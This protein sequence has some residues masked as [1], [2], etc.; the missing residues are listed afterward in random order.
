M[1]AALRQ[2]G[3]LGR[4]LDEVRLACVD[5]PPE[6]SK[7]AEWLLDN[8][9]QVQRA[10]RQIDKD[11][12]PSFYRKLS[13]LDDDADGL[14]RIYVLAHEFLRASHLQI[15]LPGAVRFIQ[16][17][18]QRQPLTIAELWAFP[19]MARIACVE[20]LAVTLTP[21]LGE[22][23]KLP[24]R[25]PSA[26]LDPHSLD[27][28]E[29]VARAISNLGVIAAIPW[30][31]FFD[32]TSLVEE[33]LGHDP[34]GHYPE[35][36]FE[37]RD[38]YRGAVER[39]AWDSHRDESE[40]TDAAIR[41]SRSFA[42]GD[43]RG[44][45]GYWLVDQG[46]S[47][48]ESELGVEVSRREKLR[49]LVK[50]HPGR[51]Y[52]A[53]LLSAGIGAL[54]LPALYLAWVGASLPGWLGAMAVS[55][56]PASVLAITVV[57]WAI[58]RVIPPSVLPK[59]DCRKRLP[60]D[61]NS[62]VVVPVVIDTKEE[63][64]SLARQLETHFLA[65]TDPRVQVAL[66]AD[67]ADAPEEE[68]PGD[69]AIVEA[70]VA[71]I[72][73]LNSR[74]AMGGHGP[75]HLLLRPRRYNSGEGS[76]MA[77]ERK[78]GKLEQF[79]RLLVEGDWS[80]FS[81]HEGIRAAFSDVRYVV[82][83]DADTLL[84]PGSVARLVGT[85][86]HPLNRAIVNRETGR[87]QRGY[88]LV[89]PRVEIS[90]QAGIRSV[91][92]RL[93]TGDTAIDIYSRAVSD[94]YQDLF[95]AG[96]YVGKGIY[97][98]RAFH[99]AVDGRVPENRILSHDLFEGALGHAALATDIV[100]YENFPASYPEYARRLHRWIRGDWQ[101]LAWLWPHVPGADG[102]RL[103][104][105]ISGIDRWKILDNLRRSLVAPGLLILA[106]AGWFVLPGSPWFWTALVVLAPG[107]QLFTDIVSGLARG[108]RVGASYGLL[109][110]LSDQTGRW[111][112]AM[113]YLLH[114]ALLSLHAIMVTLWRNLVSHKHLL[115]WTAAAHVA[116]RISQRS[117]RFSNWREMWLGPVIAVTI[118]TALVLLR[119][120]ALPAAL[121]LLVPWM[122]APE[123]AL[124]SGRPRRPKAVP[125]GKGDTSY[126]RLL[127]R[128]TWYYF[129]S[130]AGPE[131][132][133]LPP[134][135]Y[136]GP[137]FEEIAHRTSPT[138]I[139]MLLL[140]TASAWD[141]G[142][143]GRAELAARGHNVFDALA[144]L[145]RYRG[146]FYNW[147]ETRHLHP[148]EPRYVSVV[149]SG[150]LAVSLIAY[151][152]TLRQAASQNALE[153]QRWTGLADLLELV[154]QA[155][156]HFE[157]ANGLRS[158]IAEL[159]AKVKE[160]EDGGDP[161]SSLEW[162]RSTVLPSIAEA[163]KHLAQSAADTGQEPLHDLFAWIDRLRHHIDEMHR[164]HATS[165]DRSDDLTADLQALAEDATTLAWSMDFSW[166]YDRERRLF[167]I[168]HNVTASRIDT[169]HY[170]LLASEARL[171]SFFAIAKGDV[172]IEHWFH[173]ERPVT[174]GP[175]GLS[176]MSWNGSMFEYLMPRLLLRGE[177]ETLLGE[178]ERV[179]VEIQRRYGKARGLPWGVS[180]SAYAERDP[181]HRYRYQAFGIP[182]LGL[183]RGL[184]RDQVIAP[185]ASGLALAV[186][187][188]QATANLRALSGLGAE[189]RYGMWEALDFTPDRAPANGR[190]TPVV[191]YMAHHQGMMLCAIA[192]LLTN[193]RMVARFAGG[194]QIWLVSLLL[195][196]RVPHEIPPEI[197]RREAL[198]LPDSAGH[199]EA[200]APWEPALRRSR[201]CKCL[202][203][204]ACRAGFPK[205]GAA[206]CVGREI[207]S[208]GSSRTQRATRT[209]CGFIFMTRI[210]AR[211]GP[212]PVSRR[213]RLLTNSEFSSSLTSSNSIAATTVST[214]GW[215]WVWVVATIWKF[216]D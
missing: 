79:N 98:V 118:A 106:L 19:T 15:S 113:V 131:D 75:F 25:P 46:C 53:T 103:K 199:V 83:V 6:A 77:W 73:S 156:S 160:L 70:L 214:R 188:G 198:E 177:P 5:P 124:W 11:M 78:R 157:Q 180:E 9:Y 85:I 175:G 93:F 112:Q 211:H 38:N 42:S 67:L 1:V 212:Q 97:D 35:M 16:G 126:L 132:N 69:H 201:K 166:L 120:S 61:A 24:F 155:A 143:L 86:S 13:A 2:I 119:P 43:I 76:W 205:A 107:W 29:C 49:K 95:G 47:E 45:V 174:R 30:E 12:P 59:L 96:I 204:V 104:N 109:A 134:D 153:A 170:D 41:L 44:H 191:A 136:Q 56:I 39:L 165:R 195:S 108:R 144:R 20:V 162:M 8:D 184:A 130:F 179:A 121:W 62:F 68:M 125:L 183:K 89:Q 142:Y 34:S 200:I 100:L 64:A 27:Q 28:T 135:N 182:G 164:D 146:H 141:M 167:F 94:V 99:A 181:E 31:D 14:P 148:L 186:A 137:P 138:N 115:E 92:A 66:L 202:A 80:A 213:A 215:K 40:V 63:V 172:P 189:G 54:I 72:R 185:Y 48:L 51:F 207:R 140:S 37:T 187:P 33:A 194:A 52:T 32:Q 209:E 74:H 133:W 192:N 193:D 208:P 87:V 23:I 110:R 139:G 190:F 176:L 22:R 26:A 3:A 81:V 82:T 65:N 101:L 169:H 127:A 129:E 90:P 128:R 151:A 55:L 210:A 71:A 84:P 123:I 197:E 111:L 60:D 203:M 158:Q 168:G 4:W 114:E 154:D 10:L 21:M 173:L 57:H 163:A 206:P 102:T 152:E 161:A 7:A 88:A 216:A 58:T 91:F 105:S 117:A 36:D 196:E 50:A 147:Y 145:E 159:R 116:A 17:Y 149:D 18:Q 178:S 171:A 150:N 122:L